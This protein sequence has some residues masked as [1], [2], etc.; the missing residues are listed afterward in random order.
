MGVSPNNEFFLLS[1]LLGPSSMFFSLRGVQR[2]AVMSDLMVLLLWKKATGFGSFSLCYDDEHAWRLT[3]GNCNNRTT[4]VQVSSLF[5]FPLSL[6][7]QADHFISQLYT[8]WHRS[9]PC[10]Y[11]SRSSF[12][13]RIGALHTHSTASHSLSYPEFNR[14]IFPRLLSVFLSL[15]SLQSHTSRVMGPT[16]GS[17]AAIINHYE[18]ALGVIAA[19]CINRLQP[20]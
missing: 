10:D 4:F 8:T 13:H 14:S 3:H 2:S 12:V 7:P 15:F 18:T 20:W 16:Y 19:T 6:L 9:M 11:L 17:I 5:D 1:D